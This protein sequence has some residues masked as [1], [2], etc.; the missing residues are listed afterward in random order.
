M[1]TPAKLMPYVR[2]GEGYAAYRG[3]VAGGSLH[4]HAAFQIAI[5]GRGELVMVDPAGTRHRAAAL[6]VS[7]MTRHRML[8][9]AEVLTYFVEPHSAFA[10][11]LRDR[12]DSGIAAAPELCGVREH[13]VVWH[14]RAGQGGGLDPRLMQAVEMLR[15]SDIPTSVLAT[16][17]GLSPQRLRALA[18]HELG[19]SLTRWR[20]WSRLRRAVQA[21][22]V[23]ASVADAAASAGFS[24]QAHLTRQ[25]REMLGFTPAV[26]LSVL[27]DQSLPAT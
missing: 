20:V 19:L 2:L 10:D 17:I 24:D 13:D 25:M 4:R 11:R 1:D 9:T 22:Q 21:L 5:A 27:R 12:Y 15:D 14:A 7:P 23:G 3:P 26:T 6:V 18:R 8:A 16:A